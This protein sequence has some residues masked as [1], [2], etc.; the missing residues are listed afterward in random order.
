MNRKDS[1]KISLLLFI[2]SKQGFV[3]VKIGTPGAASVYGGEEAP[4]VD[5][6]G[7]VGW[8]FVKDGASPAAAKINW[9]VGPAANET[10]SYS[11]LSAYWS[12]ITIDDF[13]DG[14]S[15]PWLQIFTKPKG[16]G[17]DA[18]WYRSKLDLQLAPRELVRPGERVCIYWGKHHP[19][20]DKLDGARLIHLHQ[21]LTGPAILPDDKIFLMPLA[22]DS[23]ATSVGLC[24]ET[25]A[26]ELNS[27]S[28]ESRMINMHLVG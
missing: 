14:A 17:N 22:T 9:Y 8:S 3:Q 6:A 7:R 12:I 23:G 1:E 5:A 26:Y 16:D 4:I 28:P 21:T 27:H 10:I 24:A 11:Q 19:P 2:M 18:S 15:L 20:A 13:T 25:I